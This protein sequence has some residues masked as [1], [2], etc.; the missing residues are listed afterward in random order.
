MN[1][2]VTAFGSSE[3]FKYSCG[4]L[5]CIQKYLFNIIYE[6]PM[7]TSSSSFICSNILHNE[8][9]VNESKRRCR[10]EP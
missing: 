1:I 7:I 4:F 5:L 10:T 2:L 8:W 6:S 9:S 3:Y